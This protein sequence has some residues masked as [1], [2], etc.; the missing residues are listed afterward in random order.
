MWRNEQ[1]TDA[2]VTG[3]PAQ[4]SRTPLLNEGLMF[5]PRTESARMN[6]LSFSAVTT[7]SFALGLR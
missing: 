3:L 1:D 2:G 7:L 4:N 6:A 5:T